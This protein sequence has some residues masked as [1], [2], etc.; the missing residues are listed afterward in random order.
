MTRDLYI[1]CSRDAATITQ[2]ASRGQRMIDD[3]EDLWDVPTLFRVLYVF[4]L[5]A[6]LVIE[7]L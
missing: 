1:M 3:G 5:S 2:A 4:F 7:L 6:I